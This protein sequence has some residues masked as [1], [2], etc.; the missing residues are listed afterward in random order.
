LTE[1]GV[2]PIDGKGRFI[3]LPKFLFTDFFQLQGRLKET[4][5]KEN[6]RRSQVVDEKGRLFDLLI[7]D[8][9]EPL[10]IIS[11]SACSLLQKAERYGPLT[12]R[13][14]TSLERILRNTR[15]AQSLVREM[16][17]VARSEEG[18]F[19]KESFSVGTTLRESLLDVLEFALPHWTE[20]L[21]CIGDQE[22]FRIMLGEKGIFTEISGRYCRSPFCHDQTK[23]RQ[24]LRNL[25]S[26][27][28]KYR[29]ERMVVCLSGE[30][31]LVVS[32][33]DDGIG[34]PAGEQESV[35]ERFVRLKSEK[36]T[37]IPGLGLGLP[38]VKALV[39]AMG[40]EI[41]L[42]SREGIGTRF[43]VRIPPLR[44]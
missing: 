35:F 25:I 22:E 23:V 30:T 24:I 9:S 3:H 6:H 15:K 13:Q 7:H 27:A 36:R 42:V 17:E 8:L 31:D 11:T 26:N 12:D 28:L 14:K 19:Q 32:V 39:E 2:S 4:K 16:V 10:S 5:E 40:G 44:E 34:I 33:E 43:M 29:R 1:G 21:C 18:V 41:S 20:K 38:G 37:E